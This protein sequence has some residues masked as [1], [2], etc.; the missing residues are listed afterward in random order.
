MDDEESR[1]LESQ[2][3]SFVVRI[4]LEEP[5]SAMRGA[6]WRGHITHVPSGRRRYVTHLDEI[7]AFIAGY[8]AEMRG[9]AP[10]SEE[11]RAW[12]EQHLRRLLG[13]GE[14]RDRGA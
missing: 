7:T 14:V 1:F 5:A 4:W 3:R 2:V 8:L 13:L 11:G 6:V 10:L 9:R 12:L